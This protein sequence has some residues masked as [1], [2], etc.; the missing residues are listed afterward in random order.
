VGQDR[1]DGNGGDLG[2]AVGLA[3]ARRAVRVLD[4]AGPVAR[5][6]AA[7]HV[8]EFVPDRN[9]A[10]GAETPWGLAEPLAAL[11]PGT[12]S[13]R[14]DADAVTEPSLAAE[15]LAP[16]QGRPLVLVV[17]DAHRHGWMS[18]AVGRL[19]SA[20]PDAV[21]VEMGLPAAGPGRA[22]LATYGAT[23]ANAQAAAEVLAGTR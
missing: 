12:T 1:V 13:V 10:I 16:A 22:H 14:L 17:R 23:R 20:R 21:V 19:L 3:A 18:G 5:L 15:A 11:L 6:T 8:V 9:I 4:G 7:P 2:S